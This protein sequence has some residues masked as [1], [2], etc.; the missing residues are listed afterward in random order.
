MN[1]IMLDCGTVTTHT[2]LICKVPWFWLRWADKL[3]DRSLLR[4]CGVIIMIFDDDET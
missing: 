4:I 1:L 2:K 3:G